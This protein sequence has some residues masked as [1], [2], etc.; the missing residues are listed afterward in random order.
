MCKV[1]HKH[2]ALI[3]AW[4]DGA[5]I[6]RANGLGGWWGVGN[7]PLWDTDAEYRIKPETKPDVVLY[8]SYNPLQV[9]GAD[10]RAVYPF[11]LTK[12]QSC[13]DEVKFTFDGE[14]GKLKAVELIN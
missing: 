7:A 12:Q 1:P 3:K 11:C 8:G 10:Q 9:L 5:E 2:A 14:S 13:V 6:Q 4:A